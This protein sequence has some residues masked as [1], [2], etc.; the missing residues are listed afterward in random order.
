VM[1]SVYERDYLTVP[2]ATDG[3]QTFHSQADLDRTI[4]ELET[5][6]R[7]AAANLEFE[8]AARL[9]DDLRKLRDP[10]RVLVGG[11]G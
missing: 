6:M 4:A 1:S 7:A 10:G 11:G 3:R 2:A 5:G 9:R 8:R